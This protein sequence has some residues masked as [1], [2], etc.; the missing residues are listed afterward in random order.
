MTTPT[1]EQAAKQLYA[2]G[3]SVYEYDENKAT[4]ILQKIYPDSQILDDFNK[5]SFDIY[6]ELIRIESQKT[7]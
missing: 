6:F 5:M 1:A 2:K 3:M 4:Y 7:T